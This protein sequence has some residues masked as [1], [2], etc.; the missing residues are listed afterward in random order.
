MGELNEIIP[1]KNQSINKWWWL[2][3]WW[4]VVVA[5]NKNNDHLIQI[6]V[7]ENSSVRKHVEL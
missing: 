6:S 2:H 4:V 5:H 7:E 1:G 3:W